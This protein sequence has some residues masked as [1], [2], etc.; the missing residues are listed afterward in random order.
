MNQRN[1]SVSS[2][3]SY[4]KGEIVSEPTTRT[5]LILGGLGVFGVARRNRKAKK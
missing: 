1:K 2:F 5:L 3:G 4:A